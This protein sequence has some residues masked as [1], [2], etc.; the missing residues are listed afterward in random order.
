MG[1]PRPRPCRLSRPN[2][3]A[4]A[5]LYDPA[6][7]RLCSRAIGA[8]P[9]GKAADFESAIRRFE[10]FRPNQF[11]FVAVSGTYPVYAGPMCTKR[12]PIPVAQ[13]GGGPCLL[14]AITSS[15]GAEST[16]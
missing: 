4:G 10:S 1:R 6:R 15:V 13:H 2:G 16:I 12:V 9:S 14:G 5:A 7:E 11:T 3:G 8:S